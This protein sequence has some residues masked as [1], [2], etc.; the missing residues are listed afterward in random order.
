MTKA[1]LIEKYGIEWYEE[2][3]AKIR[4]RFMERYNNDIEYKERYKNNAE[5]REYHKAKARDWNKER[6][7]I[8]EEYTL[9]QRLAHSRKYCREG[10][11]SKIENYEL[12]K[13]DNFKGWCI[14]HRLELTLDG[15]YAHSKEELKRMDM[16][17]N[18][19]YFELIY[20]TKS[21]HMKLHKCVKVNKQ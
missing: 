15:E 4:K 7:N 1:E 18:R 12:A 19:P 8:D 9:K 2:H 13:A 20:L 16:Y 14:H 10:E 5:Y 3:K 11:E 21:E 6:Y 17:Y